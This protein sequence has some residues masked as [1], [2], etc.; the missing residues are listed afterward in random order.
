M[1]PSMSPR[2][3]MK[4][5]PNGPSPYSPR[6][7]SPHHSA[8]LLANHRNINSLIQPPVS[9]DSRQF[10]PQANV[11]SH[12]V[13]GQIGSFHQQRL[14]H[15]QNSVL[16]HTSTS[17][18]GSMQMQ[19]LQAQ[20]GHDGMI[21][22]NRSSNNDSHPVA[23]GLSPPQMYG[24]HHPNKPQAV[25]HSNNI[26]LPNH[27]LSQNVSQS[28]QS[29]AKPIPGIP[30]HTRPC[31]TTNKNTQSSHELEQLLREQMLTSM[32]ARSTSSRSATQS[33]VHQ[34]QI[35][36][37]NAQTIRPSANHKQSQHVGSAQ[38]LP[39]ANTSRQQDG[40]RAIPPQGIRFENKLSNASRTVQ[41]PAQPIEHIR[42]PQPDFNAS[43]QQQHNVN[44]SQ[45][46][47]K[48]SSQSAINRSQPAAN[49]R[50]QPVVNSRSQPVVS[51]R[52]QPVVS[53]RSQ[54]VVS[55]RSQPSASS[56]SQPAANI[57]SQPASSSR[58]QPVANSRSQPVGN[59][60]SQPVANSR[61]QPASS[62][63]SHPVVSSRSQ[64][65]SSSRSQPAVSSR[66]PPA[67]NNVQPQAASKPVRSPASANVKR[68]AAGVDLS[69]LQRAAN[70][71]RLQHAE[72]IRQSQKSAKSS[73][74][75]GTSKSKS[76]QPTA[77]T[78]QLQSTERSKPSQYVSNVSRSQTAPKSKP[79]V[80]ATRRLQDSA[81]TNYA[82]SSK[83][84]R[85]SQ[86]IP[87]SNL[88]Q[89]A[90]PYRIDSDQLVQ[91]NIPG[92]SNQ[93]IHY[94][95]PIR[96]GTS[97]IF[98]LPPEMTNNRQ[99]NVVDFSVSYIDIPAIMCQ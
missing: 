29:S 39:R 79:S 6:N 65:A 60:R 89:N 55:S 44:R 14:M 77:N 75:Q 56:R 64:P 20:S 46:T 74:Q 27:A 62:S 36:V 23:M 19:C 90:V 91:T 72:S 22:P 85:Q 47:A 38:S 21:N 30:Q 82:Q 50:L 86:S 61:S 8:H 71:I 53:S 69:Q 33:V 28:M 78:S 67:A 34:S 7:T 95:T 66:S 32:S 87:R 73:P 16:T 98:S 45:P 10:M 9:A 43:R 58:S 26:T 5:P 54:P 40:Q 93:T 48:S 59:S 96:S 52:S 88:T 63:R 70:A 24:V 41:R 15:N 25:H 37:C 57:R 84:G 18:S 31:I 94:T 17:Q 92:A 11:P 80:P 12:G 13:S 3:V 97:D 76:S 2:T 68:L 42:K 83:T 35:P 1:Q 99:G 4:T 51:S 81:T 49:S